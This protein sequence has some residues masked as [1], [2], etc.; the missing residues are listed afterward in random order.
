M[1]LCSSS[2]DLILTCTPGLASDLHVTIILPDDLDSWWNLAAFPGL[3]CSSTS[4]TMRL[5][6]GWW[7]ACP[8]VC[9]TLL[10][11][12]SL[13]EQLELTLSWHPRAKSRKPEP[14]KSHSTW[15][16]SD[17]W[18][19]CRLFHLNGCFTHPEMR[20][21]LKVYVWFG[22]ANLLAPVLQHLDDK[23]LG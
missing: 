15:S 1:L 14:V 12:L 10:G 3:P 7:G 16:S 11:S 23:E 18:R 13:G 8:A 21:L 6:P 22:K 5:E 17:F 2:S 4:G 19:R 20:S 9:V